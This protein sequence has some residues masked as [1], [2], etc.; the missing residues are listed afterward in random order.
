MNKEKTVTPISGITV[1]KNF[2]KFCFLVAFF[3]VAEC[4]QEG[5]VPYFVGVADEADE[6]DHPE[7]RPEKRAAAGFW[8]ADFHLD[9][10]F[11]EIGEQIDFLIGAASHQSL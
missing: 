11:T 2:D 10:A 3:E 8:K 4:L 7:Y 1:F 9:M 5:C 6:G